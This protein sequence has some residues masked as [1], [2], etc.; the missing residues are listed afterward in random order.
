ML[1]RLRKALMQKGRLSK[2]IINSITGLPYETTYTKHFG[3]LRNAYRLIGYNN[4]KYWDNL[5][6][7]RQWLDL[8]YGHASQLCEAFEKVG[9]RAAFDSWVGCLRVDDAVNVCFGLAKWC[10]YEGQCVRWRL[11]CRKRWPA[12]GWTVALRLGANRKSIQDYILLPTPSSRIGGVPWI[13]E[14]NLETYNIEVFQTFSELARSLVRHIKKGTRV[15]PNTLPRSKAIV[16]GSGN[17]RRSPA[18]RK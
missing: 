2:S 14:T 1:A 10:K 5:E 9:E 15:V 11:F 18:R 16:S 17:G 13:T 8:C 12:Q 4:T 7:H 6:I 3:S